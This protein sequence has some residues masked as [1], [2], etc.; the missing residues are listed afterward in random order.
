LGYANWLG[1]PAPIWITVAC[2][3]LFGFL[4]NK[5]TFGRNTLA[6]GGNEE[7]ARLA[8]VPVGTHQDC[9]LYAVRAG[10]RRCRHHSGFAY[11]QRPAN[12]LDRL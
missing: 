4:L 8:G 3:I 1:L 7:A 10:F 12:D 6:I 2:L 11:D 5:T 9:D